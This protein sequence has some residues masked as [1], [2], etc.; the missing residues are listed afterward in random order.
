MQNLR[1]TDDSGSNNWSQHF[2]SICRIFGLLT[3]RT[4]ITGVSAYGLVV[5]NPQSVALK[6]LLMCPTVDLLATS[7]LVSP[8]RGSIEFVRAT[9]DSN[10]C[11]RWVFVL[12]HH[13]R[14]TCLINRAP[15][16]LSSENLDD[17]AI[18]W[19]EGIDV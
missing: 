18:Q 15:S 19:L 14:T 6:T 13:F 5:G 12:L 1:S 3:T 16:K 17:A 10:T 4:L 9:G 8:G 11:S 7:C 2:G